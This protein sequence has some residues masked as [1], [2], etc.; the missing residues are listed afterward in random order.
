[1]WLMAIMA[2]SQDPA[3]SKFLRR[4]AH[5]LLGCAIIFLLLGFVSSA[6]KARVD[7]YLP[8]PQGSHTITNVI[9]MDVPQLQ[10][11]ELVA[12]TE[13]SWEGC[14]LGSEPLPPSSSVEHKSDVLL[15]FHPLRSPPLRSA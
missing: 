1:M 3:R 5:L 6:T 13:I 2:S 15:A 12:V 11:A 14:Q 10:V 9:R 4:T 8:L 7:R